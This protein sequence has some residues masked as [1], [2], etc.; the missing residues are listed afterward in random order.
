MEYERNHTLAYEKEFINN[1]GGHKPPCIR[2]PDYCNRSYAWWLQRYIEVA[3]LA[4]GFL[5]E[6]WRTQAFAYAKKRLE[7]EV[8]WTGKADDLE[9]QRHRKEMKG[10]G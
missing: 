1:L 4:A 5:T 6:A 10:A 8:K 9:Y 7:K 3:P 2:T